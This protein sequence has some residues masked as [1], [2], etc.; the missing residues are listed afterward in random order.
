MH[1]VIIGNGIAGITASRHIRKISDHHISVISSE[2]DHFFSRTALMY[3][4]MGHMKYEH[5]KP[6]EDWFWD[7]NKIELIRDHVTSVNRSKRELTLRSGGNIQYDKLIL[8]TGSKP[9]LPD[10]PGINLGGVQGLYSLQDLDLMDANTEN[11]KQAVV[12]GGGLIGVEMAEMLHSRGIRVVFLVREKSFWN[13]VL[14]PEESTI[15]NQHI[16]DHGIDLRLN[17]QLKEIRGT[18]SSVTSVITDQEEEIAADFVGITIGVLPNAELA[19]QSGLEV[20]NGI[21]VDDYL[22]TNDD[23]IYAIGDCAEL[24]QPKPERRAIEPVWYTGRMMGETVAETLCNEP[25]AYD[26]GVWFNSAKFFN[27]E[28]QTYGTVPTIKKPGYQQ[29]YWEQGNR[30]IRFVFQDDNQAL[31]GVNTI[32]FRLDH[33]KLDQWIYEAYPI[34]EVIN[35]LQEISFDPEFSKDYREEIRELFSSQFPDLT[36]KKLN[37]KRGILRRLF[38]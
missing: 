17:T 23:H 27:L 4:Y 30:C 21:L 38:A 20:S 14:P 24:R 13:V 28:Y 33:R 34:G 18:G 1:I 5:T 10:W 12:V 25:L 2:S 9:N 11:I 19:R 36:V 3:I 15:I 31:S 6:Y 37:K 16:Q 22:K 29:F 7:K 35:R 8:A 26:P 32:G